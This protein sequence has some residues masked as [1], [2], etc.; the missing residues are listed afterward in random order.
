[1]AR[2]AYL[3]SRSVLK[4]SGDLPDSAAGWRRY[5]AYLGVLAEEEVQLREARFGRLSRGWVIGSAAFKAELK[6]ELAHEAGAHERF[7]LLGGDREA[8]QQLK[9]E[10][11]EEQLVRA[12]KA[13][14]VDLADLPI[15]QSAPEKVQ[16][17]AIMKTASSVSNGW[18]AERLA[19]GAPGNVSQ[20][21]RRFRIG[22]GAQRRAF[23]RAV[24]Q[25]LT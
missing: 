9:T 25:V 16:L 23:Q 24:S 6:K 13:L 10:L 2:P 3:E 22:G 20:Y 15:R 14:A 11:W 19:M 7:A 5:L 8:Q 18:L 17:A 1:M 4:E 12:A 21:V